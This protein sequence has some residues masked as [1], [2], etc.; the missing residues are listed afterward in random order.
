MAKHIE[1]HISSLLSE[2]D[3]E[4]L[5]MFCDKARRLAATKLAS[6]GGTGI[7]GKIRY[8]RDKGLWFESELPPEEQV[9]EFLMAFRFFYL[10]K[11]PTHFLK[12]ISLIGRHTNNQDVRRALKVFGKQW[13]DF[14]FGKAFNIQFN[15]TPITSS[16]LL[17]LWFNAHYFH[18]NKDKEGELNKLKEGFSENFAK[19]M[20]LDAAF[21]AT[22]I[23]FKIFNGLQG[24]VDEH[25]SA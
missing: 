21:E 1:V 20:L 17:D 16:L 18:S 12:V 7:R 5:R 19:Y 3:W 23:I 11:E 24:I 15:D 4:I 6:E 10:Q 2:N 22:K 25:F 8:E 9:A 14:L 13:N